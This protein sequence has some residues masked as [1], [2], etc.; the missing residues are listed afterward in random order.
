MLL[1]QTQPEFITNVKAAE[2]K[3]DTEFVCEVDGIIYSL[4]TIFIR[5]Q[6]THYQ[7]GEVHD[8]TTVK[9]TMNTPEGS[10]TRCFVWTNQQ[11]LEHGRSVDDAPNWVHDFVIQHNTKSE[12]SIAFS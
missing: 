6:T 2:Y 5:T 4:R 11:P 10:Y 3:P 12:S 9:T 1:K 7:T 8:F